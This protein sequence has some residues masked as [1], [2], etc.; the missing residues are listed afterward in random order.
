MTVA[1]NPKEYIVT[2]E[3][4]NHRKNIK[5]LK[6]GAKGMDFENY[7]KRI[8]SVIDIENFGQLFT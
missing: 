7:S 1:V 6:K 5:V 3:S 8:N 4:E 2:F